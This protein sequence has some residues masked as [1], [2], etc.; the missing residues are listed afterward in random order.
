M[1]LFYEKGYE[2]TS[3]ADI[4]KEMDITKGL[5]YRYYESKQALFQSVI[6]EYAEECCEGFLPALQDRSKDM[7]ERLAGL[8]MSMICPE[9]GRYHDFFHKPGNEMIHDLIT[10]MICRYMLPHVEAELQDHF[11]GTGRSAAEVSMIDE[12]VNGGHIRKRI[13]TVEK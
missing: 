7:K 4:A 11:R 3:M 10:V 6:D 2:N 12:T 8:M 13:S 5:C 9:E 1:K